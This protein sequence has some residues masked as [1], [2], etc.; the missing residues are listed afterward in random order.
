MDFRKTAAA[1]GLAGALLFTSACSTSETAAPDATA[2]PSATAS[3]A[4]APAPSADTVISKTLPSGLIA[5][6]VANDGKGDYLQTSIADTDPAMKYNPAITDS[7]AKAHFSEVDL[8]E[9]QKVIVR[10][11]AEE[12]IDSTLNGARGDIDGWFAAHKDQIHPVNQPIMLKD[13]KGDNGDKS[14]LDTESWMATKAGYSYVHGASTPRVTA[15]TITPTQLTYVESPELQGVMLDT[16]ATYSMAVTG[17]SHGNVQ[18]TTA[19]ISF[20]AAKD[21]ADGKWKI[22]GY[23]VA[24]HT[25][26]G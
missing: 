5:K 18:R 17:G 23:N 12:A 15:R 14:I 20:A 3:Q 7:A 26:E 8:A 10:F 9:A 11:I 25:T 24:Y 2:A 13:M 19:E 21:A 4:P 22:A 16:K 1:A 6:G